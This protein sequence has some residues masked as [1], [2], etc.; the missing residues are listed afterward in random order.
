[1][2]KLLGW[3]SSGL[4]G[5]LAKF[6]ISWAL[7]FVGKYFIEKVLNNQLGELLDKKLLD[8]DNADDSRLAREVLLW[9]EKKVPDNKDGDQ[10]EKFAAFLV[11]LFPLLKPSEAKLVEWAD[12]GL[13][14]LDKTLKEREAKQ[15]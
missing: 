2:G 6:G 7:G 14:Q 9:V 1:M 10:A 11:K 12:S 5:M 8:M 3:A 15:P 13:E 4:K